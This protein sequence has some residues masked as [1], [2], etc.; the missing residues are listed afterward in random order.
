MRNF[1]P[2]E[3]KFEVKTEHEAIVRKIYSNGFAFENVKDASDAIRAFRLSAKVEEF[4]DNVKITITEMPKIE[5]KIPEIP[6]LTIYG[7]N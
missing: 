1:K 6:V 3:L 7:S 2:I 4:N 5:Y